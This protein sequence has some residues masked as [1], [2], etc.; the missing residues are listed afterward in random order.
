MRAFFASALVA[1]IATAEE[2]NQ[3]FFPHGAPH[4]GGFFGHGDAHVTAAPHYQDFWGHH[5]APHHDVTLHHEA[6]HHAGFYGHGDAHH[7]AYPSHD[8]YAAPHHVTHEV[9]PH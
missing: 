4:H 1:A 3:I 8:L 7:A 9:N 5:E 6:P 2:D